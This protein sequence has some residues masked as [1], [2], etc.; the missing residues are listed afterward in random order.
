MAFYAKLFFNS[1]LFIVVKVRADLLE[2]E[3]LKKFDNIF[4][5]SVGFLNESDN[6]SDYASKIQAIF[7]PKQPI[8]TAAP[9][10]N[11]TDVLKN[12]PEI[13]EIGTENYRI[14]DVHKIVGTCCLSCSC[15]RRTCTEDG[16]CCLSKIIADAIENNPD[17]DDQNAIDVLSALNEASEQKDENEAAIHS[18]CIKASWLSYRDKN[19][20]EIE[21]DLDIPSYFMIT[22]CFENHASQVEV[23]KCQNPTEY[24]TLTMLPVRSSDTGRIYWNVHCARCNNDGRHITQWNA[25]VR[26]DTDIA[27]FINTSD[28]AHDYGSSVYPDKYSDIPGFISKTGN[29][30]YTPPF[31]Q[32]DKLCLRKNTLLTCKINGNEPTGSWLE[33]ACEAIY[34]PLIIE[35][36]FGRIPYLNIFCYLCRREY[37]KL[38]TGGTCGYDELYLK[39]TSEGMGALLD[40]KAP[41][42]DDN[43]LTISTRQD[44]CGCEEIYD[45]NL[46][47]TIT[48]SI[49][50]RSIT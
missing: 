19:A 28:I 41:N 33:T 11:R 38:K 18:E 29:I 44:K 46:V 13:I 3:N 40:Y 12:L 47:S 6:V 39:G 49:L 32:E 4:D 34:S 14:E 15:D 30:L 36:V 48:R 8:C 31:A 45:P 23:T 10:Q 50:L 2:S 21:A 20:Y 5:F 17:M 22:R 1:L 7:C 43:A 25:S 27:Y 26:F 37:I 16:N 24:D 9:D 42:D 35:S